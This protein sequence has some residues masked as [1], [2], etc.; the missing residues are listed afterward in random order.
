MEELMR[1]I[2]QLGIG[3]GIITIVITLV[4]FAASI[5]FTIW[6]LRYVRR[7]F[8]GSLGANSDILAN[9]VMAQA[10]ILKAW[11]TGMMVN[12]NPQIG[13]LLQVQP[14]DGN[15][16]Q[17]E[18][19][20]VVSQLKLAQLQEGSLVPVKIDPNDRSHVALAL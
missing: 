7:N 16:Y 19:K 11:Q 9:G 13:L 2:T 17:A 1:Q 15:P 10:T 4:I 12:Y 14:A 8:L 6:I 5:A 18:T 3:I 20:A